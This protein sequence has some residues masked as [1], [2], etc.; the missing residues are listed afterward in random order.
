MHGRL[1]V[2]FANVSCMSQS[3][4]YLRAERFKSRRTNVCDEAWLEHPSEL[5]V[6]DQID[7]A[8]AV[9]WL[10]NRLL[11]LKLLRCSTSAVVLPAL[12]CII[13]QD[14]LKSVP[15]GFR[16]SWLIHANNSVC[17]WPLSSCSVMKKIQAY[18]IGWSLAWDMGAPLE[19]RK[20]ETRNGVETS[21]FPMK[22]EVQRCPLNGRGSCQTS[23]I[24]RGQFWNIIKKKD[25]QLT[26]QLTQLCCKANC[27]LQFTTEEEDLALACC[28]K[29][30]WT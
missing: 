23:G 17:R 25:K 20:Q 28:Q 10:T 22:A 1:L 5:R 24:W 27:N 6:Q 21:W 4:V 16:D 8:N 18:W 9:I 30:P 11:C 2:Q 7:L 15:G 26:V 29:T 12:H 14:T 13:T 3:K 19:P